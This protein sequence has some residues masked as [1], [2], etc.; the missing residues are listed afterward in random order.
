LINP[1]DAPVAANIV[2]AA[3]L[4]GTANSDSARS[5]I[6]VTLSPVHGF[7]TVYQRP[8]AVQTRNS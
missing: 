2:N 3:R 1:G 5:E 4:P 6:E 7:G 8:H